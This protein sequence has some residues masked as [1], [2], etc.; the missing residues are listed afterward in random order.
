MLLKFVLYI[1]FTKAALAGIVQDPEM[2]WCIERNA[3]SDKKQLECLKSLDVSQTLKINFSELVKQR[4]TC[5]R[6]KASVIDG[7]KFFFLFHLSFMVVAVKLPS[8]GPGYDVHIIFRERPKEDFVA[9]MDYDAENK[10][11]KLGLIDTMDP[12]KKMT[13]L[14]G[15]L[16]AHEFDRFWF[17]KSS[18]H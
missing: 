14:I 3:S 9:W 18:N 1:L 5:P 17:S 6:C 8:M 13:S 15:E 7:D 4:K 16:R 2:P 10:T 11:Y 12:S